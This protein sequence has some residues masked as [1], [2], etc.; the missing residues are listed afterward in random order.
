MPHPLSSSYKNGKKGEKMETSGVKRGRED[1]GITKLE[2]RMKRRKQM[3]GKYRNP[4]INGGGLV[5]AIHKQR[6]KKKRIG[7]REEDRLHEWCV[8]YVKTTYPDALYCGS[9]AGIPLSS[10]IAKNMVKKFGYYKDSNDFN[11]FVRRRGWGYIAFEFKNGNKGTVRPG[12]RKY[13]QRLIKQKIF[14]C[15]IRTRK[16]FKETV[17]CYMSGK[18][19]VPPVDDEKEAL[20][21][22]EMLSKFV[23]KQS[24]PSAM[25][26]HLVQV[27]RNLV[28]GNDDGQRNDSTLCLQSE[29]ESSEEKEEDYLCDDLIVFDAEE[30]EAETE[31]AAEDNCM[32]NNDSVD[33]YDEEEKEEEKRQSNGIFAVDTIFQCLNDLDQNTFGI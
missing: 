9:L 15:V 28:A 21:Y 2:R 17:D 10:P 20:D 14:A 30:E 22:C 33:I 12:Q 19:P 8:N 3:D 16:Q 24:D 23:R 31:A 29:H 1:I 25:L 26:D 7:E 13:L 5:D 32:G 6:R 18:I 27:I 4:L 11:L